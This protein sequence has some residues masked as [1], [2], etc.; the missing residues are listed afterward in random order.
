MADYVT[1]NVR[2]PKAMHERIRRLALEEN[3]SLAQIVR[4]SLVE[5]L[6]MSEELRSLVSDAAA[7]DP[8]FRVGELTLPEEVIPGDRPTD[9]SARH[10]LYLYG[11]NL[12]LLPTPAHES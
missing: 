11:V 1:T 9:T 6:T 2:L 8:I 3:K 10:D 7:D 4:E 5:Y 12:D